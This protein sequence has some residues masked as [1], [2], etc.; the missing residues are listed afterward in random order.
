MM[1]PTILVNI[2]CLIDSA[3]FV[4]VVKILLQCIDEGITAGNIEICFHPIVVII[5][6]LG[7]VDKYSAIN[8]HPTTWMD[9]L[10]AATTNLAWFV[11]VNF[12]M[13]K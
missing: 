13:R 4:I 5:G 8:V 11:A 9:Q 7:Y 10:S 6:T 1:F 2:G 3:K 12:A